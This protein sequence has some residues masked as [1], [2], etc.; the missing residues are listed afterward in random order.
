M[1]SKLLVRLILGVEA[2]DRRVEEEDNLLLVVSKLLGH[3]SV[4]HDIVD[5]I[6]WIWTYLAQNPCFAK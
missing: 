2:H 1:V 5:Q 4:D 6:I 3:V